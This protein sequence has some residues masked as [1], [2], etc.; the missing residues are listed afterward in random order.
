MSRGGQL[1]PLSLLSWQALL[2][3]QRWLWL[4]SCG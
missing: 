3:Q 2:V 4:L 1:L